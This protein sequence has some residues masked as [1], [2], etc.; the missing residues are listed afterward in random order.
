[1]SATID[2]L[3]GSEGIQQALQTLADRAK[4][5]TEADYGAITTFT[6]D[7]KLDR[8]VYTGIGD[9]DA[10]AIGDPPNGRG[11]LGTLARC[12]S[13]I[14][15][16]DVAVH[17]DHS[18]FPEGHFEVGP[19]LGVP[20]RVE[21]QTIGSIYVARGRGRTEFTIPHEKAAVVLS[22][23]AATAISL[24]LEREKGH[25]IALL[26]ERASIAHD[27][28][29]GTIQSLYA[30][31]LELDAHL[32]QPETES[33]TK[34]LLER[35]VERINELIADIRQYIGALEAHTASQIPD[36]ARD[37]P[38]ALRQLVPTG[39]DTVLSLSPTAL[40]SI[41]S[42]TAE[43]LLYI[44]REAIS[45]AVRHAEPFRIAVDMRA[46]GK[47]IA[48]TIQDNGAGFE[49]SSARVGL[50]MISMRTRATRLG[51]TLTV[52]SIPGMG[53]MVRIAMP[54]FDDAD[55]D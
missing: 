23:Q 49:Q 38:F 41:D 18:G 22:L 25:R 20:I 29:D 12:D 36:L 6:A 19:F 4:S 5:I 51:A 42:R 35:S 7:G 53:T 1:M 28:H 17:P 39:T 52:L 21:G 2:A 13:P 3:A 26:E 10:R 44:A 50:G 31:G 43:D 27:L 24:T 14:R 54:R 48:L 40:Q 55:T 9:V 45:N 15:T 16:A 32:R 37:L 47:E 30:L 11:L 46:S 34:Q 33:E 8:F